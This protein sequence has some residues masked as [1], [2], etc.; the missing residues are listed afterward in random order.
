MNAI[1]KQFLLALCLATTTFGA[2]NPIP[3]DEITLPLAAL[4]IQGTP[5]APA[6]PEVSQK[7]QPALL[8][9]AAGNNFLAGFP[10]EILENIL[11]FVQDPHSLLTFISTYDYLYPFF[12][13]RHIPQIPEV[14]GPLPEVID[15][16]RESKREGLPTTRLTIHPI[17]QKNL[18]SLPPEDAEKFHRFL[19]FNM[20]SVQTIPQALSG[21]KLGELSISEDLE[22]I[23]T[24]MKTNPHIQQLDLSSYCYRGNSHWLLH[25][26]Q[27]DLIISIFMNLSPNQLTSLVLHNMPDNRPG[28]KA[29][30]TALKRNKSLISLDLTSNGLCSEEAE[31]LAKGL[32][33]NTTLKV[34]NISKNQ[35]GNSGAKSI[36]Q[37]LRKLFRP[38]QTLSALE[39]LDI[40]ENSL[41]STSVIDFSSI[42]R[43]ND[44]TRL[45][46]LNLSNNFYLGCDQSTFSFAL[47]KNKTLT[48]LNLS[49]VKI[50][51]K[52]CQSLA[53]ALEQNETLQFLDLSHNQI[54]SEGVLALGKALEINSTLQS[55]DL[56]RNE[57]GSEAAVALGKALEINSALQSLDLSHNS[58]GPRGAL[59]LGKALEINSVLQSLDLCDNDI[60]NKGV[61]AI[62]SA[63]QTNKALTHLR[64]RHFRI[65]DFAL[66]PYFYDALAMNNTLVSLTLVS[67]RITNV[68]AHGLISALKKN[69]KS[70]M[71]YLE[72]SGNPRS[73]YGGMDF[74]PLKKE[75]ALVHPHLEVV[76]DLDH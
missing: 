28:I 22:Y 14:T 41:L 54:S 60:E 57:I 11:S 51:D 47:E 36:L 61:S 72:I 8:L 52:P 9:R 15:Y 1:Y 29:L 42:L 43:E 20:S 3:M 4:Q 70:K 65:E 26:R 18:Q 40:S 30:A 7:S 53:K 68:A 34:L 62:G 63:L 45:R 38:G 19:S 12:T 21:V 44:E 5:V 16:L 64:I 49:W 31:I 48:S 13:A 67:Q 37:S 33:A 24:V 75:L 10:D 25:Q 71:R 2:N 58:I 46:S 35:V 32:E 59:A 27:R 66:N 56:S 76:I 6:E 73:W 69:P 17:I 23:N 55:L 74:N 39:K 50:N